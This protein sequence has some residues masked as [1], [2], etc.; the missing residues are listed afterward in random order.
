M[1]ILTDIGLT[2]PA[3]EIQCATFIA[4]GSRRQPKTLQNQ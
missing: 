3:I 1:V 2:F 4:S